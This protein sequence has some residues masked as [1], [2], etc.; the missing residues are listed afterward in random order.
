MMEKTIHGFTILFFLHNSFRKRH[1]TSL[2]LFFFWLLKEEKKREILQLDGKRKE[3]E[4]RTIR[5]ATTGCSDAHWL[6]VACRWDVPIKVPLLST[7]FCTHARG[8]R[9]FSCCRARACARAF[10]R[11]YVRSHTVWSRSFTVTAACSSVNNGPEKNT[12]SFDRRRKFYYYCFNGLFVV[13]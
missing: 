8:C 3:V 7:G 1:F 11:A 4:R 12:D 13:A 6:L 9:G 10:P 5:G 2:V